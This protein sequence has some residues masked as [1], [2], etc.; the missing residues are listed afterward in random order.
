MDRLQV[1][2]ATMRQSD[3]SLVEKMGIRCDAVIANQS[4][5]YSVQEK[6]TEYGCTKMITTTTRGVGNNRNIAILAADADILLFSDDDMVYYDGTLK[7]V[8][9]AF[10]E[11]PQADMIIFSTDILKNGALVEKRHLSVKR[12]HIWNSMKYGTY[13]LGIR[14]SALRKANVMF[15]TLFGGGCI[16]GSG[17]DSLFIRDCLRKGLKVY[18]H[19]YV[20]GSCCKDSSSWFTG[21]NEKY[22]YD[23]GALF[24]YTFPKMKYLMAMYIAMK[25]QK[26]SDLPKRKMFR[27]MCKGIRGG[28]NLIPYEKTLHEDRLE[29]EAR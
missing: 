10:A 18:S 25:F 8:T 9:D 24:Q 27:L 5:A 16:Y 28:K 4:D 29:T 20:L 2:V 12:R 19:S 1:L 14:R 6:T 11:L 26:R 15:T 17:E 7:G 22:F 13:A 23:K 21:Y 3:L